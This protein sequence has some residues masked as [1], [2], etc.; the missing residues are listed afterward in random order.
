MKK[1]LLLVFIQ[2]FNISA[3]LAQ[4]Q[5]ATVL[6]VKEVCA[7]Q[8]PIIQVGGLTSLSYSSSS[9]GPQSPVTPRDLDKGD[10][11]GDGLFDV[12][13]AGNGAGLQLYLNTGNNNAFNRVPIV[14]GGTNNFSIQTIDWD[15]DSDDDFVL[16]QGSKVLLFTNDGTA[17]FT[18]QTLYTGINNLTDVAIADFDADNDWDLVVRRLGVIRFVENDGTDTFTDR[19][20]IVTGSIGT[21]SVTNQIHTVDFDKDGD[22]DVISA[23]YPNGTPKLFLNNGNYTFVASDVVPNSAAQAR[24][25][26]TADMNNDGNLDIIVGLEKSIWVVYQFFGGS[27]FIQNTIFDQYGSLGDMDVADVDNDGFVDIVATGANSDDLDV[28]YN[29]GGVGSFTYLQTGTGVNVNIF[30]RLELA[31]FE[32]DGD[33]D[34]IISQTNGTMGWITVA[35][36]TFANPASFGYQLNGVSGSVGSVHVNGAG[37]GAFNIQNDPGSQTFELKTIVDGNQID[38]STSI[39]RTYYTND[40]NTTIGI[41]RMG[42]AIN[43]GAGTPALNDV[44]HFGD[45]PNDVV[46]TLTFTIT[47][48]GTDALFI[49]S[50]AAIR[51]FASN[52][53]PFTANNLVNN[54]IPAGGSTTFDVNFNPNGLSSNYTGEVMVFS[55]DCDQPMFTFGIEASSSDPLP[56]SLIDFSTEAIDNQTLINWNTAQEVAANGFQIEWTTTQETWQTIGFVNSK[57]RAAAYEFIHPKP[58]AGINYYRLKLLDKDGQFEYSPVRTA[59]FDSSDLDDNWLSPNPTQDHIEIGLPQQFNSKLPTELRIFNNAGQLVRK[60]NFINQHTSNLGNLPN[61]L[62]YVQL[63]QNDLQVGERVVKI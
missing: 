14:T 59:V 24:I 1:N 45:R 61:G 18:E 27:V 39:T 25:I 10:F 6:P 63:R 31:D 43:N 7:N 56:I 12:L 52:N 23:S 9:F 28:F 46:S 60:S 40:P 54:N 37:T 42:Q 3:I 17:N 5:N 8:F 21:Y 34:A 38:A 15:K 47:N 58:A 32:G 55:E 29:D 16:T 26:R 53:N 4:F 13:L 57:N 30:G 44:R 2:L 36:G 33:T 41:E 51:L 62:Y 20:G 48:T 11:N 35:P 22:M 50:L 19:T 49:K